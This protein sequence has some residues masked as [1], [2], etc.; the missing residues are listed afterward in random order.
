MQPQDGIEEQVAPPHRLIRM[1]FRLFRIMEVQSG[2]ADGGNKDHAARSY[3]IAFGT[4]PHM[5]GCSCGGLYLRVVHQFLVALGR[6]GTCL[7]PGKHSGK[8]AKELGVLLTC[9][10]YAPAKHGANV[11]SPSLPISLIPAVLESP[12]SPPHPSHLLPPSNLRHPYPRASSAVCEQ[13]L[14]AC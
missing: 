12:P 3:L 5:H 14:L 2:H 13:L 10:R 9:P 1:A 6:W 4:R 8:P 11:D 7:A